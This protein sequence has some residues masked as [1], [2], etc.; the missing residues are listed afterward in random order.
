LTIPI[1]VF[2]KQL[3]NCSENLIVSRV[4]VVE[5]QIRKDFRGEW[6]VVATTVDLVEDIKLKR[7]KNLLIVLEEEQKNQFEMI[8][9]TLKN[10]QGNCPVQLDYQ[11]KK[12][13]GSLILPSQWNVQ[14]DDELLNL[15]NSLS[16]KKMA[17]V[18]Y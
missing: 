12:T 16:S 17:V 5:G 14:P 6:Q 9:N 10:H 4:V 11:T 2:S 3:I 8:M 15:L 13:Q 1:V 7:A 18:D